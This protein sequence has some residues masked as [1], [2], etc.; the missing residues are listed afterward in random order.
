MA[1]SLRYVTIHDDAQFDGAT[2]YSARIRRGNVTLRDIEFRITDP[3][4]SCGG[5]VV[6]N[7]NVTLDNTTIKT[8]NSTRPPHLSADDITLMNT[9][10]EGTGSNPAQLAVS[11]DV[12]SDTIEVFALRQEN[13]RF[14]D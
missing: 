3:N 11:G 8:A 4:T 13:M 6:E 5:I 2:Q 1:Q 7:P 10:L 14:V 9:R 12:N